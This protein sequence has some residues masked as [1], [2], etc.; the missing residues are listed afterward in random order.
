MQKYKNTY[1]PNSIRLKYFNYRQNGLYFI[2]ICTKNRFPFF[3]KVINNNMHYSQIGLIAKK[4]YKDIPNHFSFV[5]LDN[6]I[7][8]PDHLHSI[9]IINHAKFNTHPQLENQAICINEYL[10]KYTITTNCRDVACYVSTRKKVKKN[11]KFYS[12]ISPKAGSLSTIIRSFK[13]AVSK[14]A[15]QKNIQFKWQPRYYE[16]IIK[17]EN[18]LLNIRYYIKQNHIS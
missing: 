7:I 11:Q 10:P 6:F 14:Y 1:L 8:T 18:Q 17:N 15:H 3:G 2:T 5:K 9:I 12:Q 4:F 13:S 16:T